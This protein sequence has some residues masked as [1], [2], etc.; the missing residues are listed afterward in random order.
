MPNE[1]HVNGLIGITQ[2]ELNEI[3]KAVDDTS[4]GEEDST[5]EEEVT[6][7]PI[8]S[9]HVFNKELNDKEIKSYKTVRREI[10]TSCVIPESKTKENDG[11]SCTFSCKSTCDQFIS[12]QVLSTTKY[13]SFDL[14][15]LDVVLNSNSILPIQVECTLNG[16]N[17]LQYPTWISDTLN[18]VR[19]IFIPIFN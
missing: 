3:A 7:L 18:L 4:E 11:L 5:E 13:K 10:Q 17:V 6:L 16:L 19:S 1:F 15:K 9:N 14:E 8:Y 2:D 12:Y